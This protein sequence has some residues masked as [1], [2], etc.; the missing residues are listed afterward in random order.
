MMI[1]MAYNWLW[2]KY[3]QIGLSVLSYSHDTHVNI[4]I[5]KYIT[6][7]M[8][9]VYCSCICSEIRNLV[10]DLVWILI[11]MYKRDLNSLMI[12][13]ND[14]DA[15]YLDKTGLSSTFLAQ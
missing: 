7:N 11:S 3:A 10:T 2:C 12:D 13:K 8:P 9:R 5:V 15:S 14:F 4:L 6:E 1:F